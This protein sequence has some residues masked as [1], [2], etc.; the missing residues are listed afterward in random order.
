MGKPPEAEV[1]VYRFIN[2]CHVLLVEEEFEEMA[3][4]SHCISLQVLLRQPLIQNDLKSKKKTS[5]SFSFS[6]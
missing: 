4:Q 3:V 1:S 2:F 6:A 5:L